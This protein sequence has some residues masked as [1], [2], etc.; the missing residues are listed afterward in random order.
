MSIWGYQE[1]RKVKQ[2]VLSVAMKEFYGTFGI[3]QAN[4]YDF[5]HDVLKD[6]QNVHIN[7][8]LLCKKTSL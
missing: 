6:I 7:E 3:I 4:S 5:F 8:I 2:I 1:L